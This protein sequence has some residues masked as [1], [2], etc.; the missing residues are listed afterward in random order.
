MKTTRTTTYLLVTLISVAALSLVQTQSTQAQSPAY[1]LVMW[2][3]NDRNPTA[4]SETQMLKEQVIS[5]IKSQVEA[6]GAD[7]AVIVLN[8]RLT[9]HKLITNAKSLESL[10]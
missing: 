6:T 10:K 4:E 8:E 7:V 2:T 9:T 1:P 5:S 3:T